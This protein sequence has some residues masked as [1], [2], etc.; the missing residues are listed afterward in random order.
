MRSDV[1][2]LLIE[3]SQELHSVILNLSLLK[4]TSETTRTLRRAIANQ[5]RLKTIEFIPKNANTCEIFYDRGTSLLKGRC[6]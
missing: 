2:V 4:R 1:V 6:F 5:I 3:T